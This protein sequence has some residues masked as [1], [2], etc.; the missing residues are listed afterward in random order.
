MK[1]INSVIPS[2]SMG[3]TEASIKDRWVVEGVPEEVT[4]KETHTPRH[5]P[6][7]QTLFMAPGSE[8]QMLTQ[9][10]PQGPF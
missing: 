1:T 2:G 7:A 9:H 4:L 8:L 10:L 3:K 6:P 5:L